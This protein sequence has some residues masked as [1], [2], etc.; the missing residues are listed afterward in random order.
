MIKKLSIAAFSLFLLIAVLW[1]GTLGYGKLR[2]QSSEAAIKQYVIDIAAYKEKHGNYPK[3]LNTLESSI[4]NKVWDVLP[5]N[6]IKYKPIE[7]QYII[8]YVQ[9]PLGPGYV[10]SSKTKEWFYDEI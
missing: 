3:A 7:E 10:Y 6:K 9:F 1:Y 4:T 2:E 8:Y 5:S